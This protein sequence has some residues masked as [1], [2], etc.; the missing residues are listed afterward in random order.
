MSFYILINKSDVK[1][2]IIVS[3]LSFGFLVLILLT[4]S[5]NGFTCDNISLTTDKDSYYT[6]E[7]IK[8]NASWDLYYDP[9]YELSFVQIQI[10]DNFDRSLWN[11]SE[12][13]TIGISVKNWTVDIQLLDINYSNFADMLF[14]KIYN[15]YENSQTGDPVNTYKEIL[16]VNIFKTGITCQLSDFRNDLIYGETNYFTATFLNAENST[17]LINETFS[18]KTSYNEEIL[19]QTNLTTNESGE[20]EFNIS[21]VSHLNIGRNELIFNIKDSM[22]YNNTMFS[23][24]LFVRKIPIFV[25]ITKFEDNLE[26]ANYIKIQLYFYYFFNQ[27]KKPVENEIV[28]LVFYSNSTSEYDLNLMINQMGFLNISISPSNIIFQAAEKLIRIDIIFNGTGQLENKTI[29]FNLKIENFLYQG[30]SS[31]FLLSNISLF[32]ILIMLLSLISLKVYNL[33]RYKFKLIEDLTFKF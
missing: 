9:E 3:I 30:T 26:E 18:L 6:H 4:N 24:E 32:S 20:I 33:Q 13:Y 27:S 17:R 29:S 28:K 14:I 25:N 22:T 19:F 11:S 5:V 21:T 15:Y 12:Y 2:K 16:A 7:E 10:F 8:I 1:K 23:Y 31:L